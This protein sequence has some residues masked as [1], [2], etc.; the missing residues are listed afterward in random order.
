MDM[1]D[2]TREQMDTIAEAAYLARM[3]EDGQVD[4]RKWADLS[5]RERYSYRRDARTFIAMFGALHALMAGL[6]ATDAATSPR[7]RKEPAAG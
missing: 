7:K 1:S 5:V 4:F 2:L 6:Q 3:A